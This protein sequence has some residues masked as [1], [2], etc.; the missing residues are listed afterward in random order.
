MSEITRDQIEKIKTKAAAQ[1][2]LIPSKEV[3][4]LCNL[5]LKGLEADERARQAV[6]AA[7]EGAATI[8][9][10]WVTPEQR[11][12]GNGGPA[13]LIRALIKKEPKP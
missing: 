1:L 4:S 9:D 3:L 11:L 8:A 2:V 10:A 6:Q 12:Y 7:L 5:A 13:A